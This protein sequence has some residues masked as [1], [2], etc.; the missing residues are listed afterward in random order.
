MGFRTSRAAWLEVP[1]LLF[2]HLAPPFS[3]LD[4]VNKAEAIREV[5]TR[6]TKTFP[7]NTGG[8]SFEDF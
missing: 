1:F 8:I 3:A 4:F 7:P 6:E 5:P 2:P